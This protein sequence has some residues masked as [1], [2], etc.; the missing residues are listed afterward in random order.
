VHF[1]VAV[2]NLGLPLTW[3]RRHLP[4]AG[5]PGRCFGS[6]VVWADTT[7]TNETREHKNAEA[8]KKGPP[9]FRSI[10]AISFPA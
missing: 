2:R 7:S 9:R 3:S 10:G 4:R 8:L 1:Q 5:D 6:L